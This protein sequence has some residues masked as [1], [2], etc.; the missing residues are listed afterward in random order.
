MIKTAEISVFSA[1]EENIN[2]SIPIRQAEP[3][4]NTESSPIKKSIDQV[5]KC[6]DSK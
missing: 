1:K 5:S 4:Q 3:I 6:Y 2:V